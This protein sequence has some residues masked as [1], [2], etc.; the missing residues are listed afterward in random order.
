MASFSAE[1]HV[2]GHV[3]PVLHCA[4]GVR[5]AT[6]Q[7]GRVSTKVRYEPVHLTLAVPD[8]D[9]L[10]AWAADPQKRQAAAVVFRTA[11]G[12]SPLETLLLQ[13]AYAVSYHEE[14]A[15][16]DVNNGAYVCHLV[17]SDPGG[18]FIQAGG[19]AAAFVAPAAREHG[20]PAALGAAMMAAAPFVAGADGVPRLPRITGD[21]P[22]TVK[23]A[24]TVKRRNGTF[25][26]KPGLDRAEYLR[27]LAGQETGLNKLTVAQFLA[28][29]DAYL[30]RK[31]TSK[32][33]QPDGRDP[34]GDAAQKVAREDALR[35]KVL[36]LR[37][38]NRK[39]TQTEAT[40]Q[41]TQ[42]LETQTALHDP[43]QVAGGHANTISGVGDARVNSA[44][45]AAWTSRI[46]AIDRQIRGF[47]G[48]MTPEQQQ[49]TYLNIRLPVL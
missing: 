19:P 21:P 22:F 13:A 20:V 41:A 37:R 23:G 12:G 35:D 8:G 49:H 40:G 1:L 43:D 33:K 7:R 4:Y 17:L 14:F 38:Q 44:I 11:N 46:K 15:H 47:A 30:N 25:V 6:H 10:L 34:K 36:E 2:A 32:R 31:K 27:Q 39:L 28:N 29:R 3:F 18:F 45:G 5:Q 48:A 26:T 42:W 16:G 9:A 24:T